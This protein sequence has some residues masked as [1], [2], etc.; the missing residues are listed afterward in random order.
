MSKIIPLSVAIK[1]TS[2]EEITEVTIT[3]TMKQ[4]GALRGLKLYDV[5]TSDVNSLITLLPRVTSPRLT[6]VELASMNIQDF[7]ELA[8]GVADFLA[9]SS[10]PEATVSDDAL[11]DAQA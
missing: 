7:A 6:E 9:P 1:R 3:D 4:V 8:A 10:E 11:S 2:G 5:M